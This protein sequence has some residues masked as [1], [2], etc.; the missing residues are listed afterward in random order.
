MNNE[1]IQIVKQTLEQKREKL[2]DTI[3][4]LKELVRP[5]APDC[6]I[7]R[8]SRMDAINNRSINESALRKKK[9]Q[10][11]NIELALRKVDQPGFGRCIRC[12]NT[13]PI[14]RIMLMPESNVCV[15]CAR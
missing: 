9:L 7:G 8:V 10:L 2:I 11:A 13:I 3:E 5:E 6:A 4:E 14:A 1:E 12:G 15:T